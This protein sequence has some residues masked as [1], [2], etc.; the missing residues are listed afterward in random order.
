M[1]T[2]VRLNQYER[3]IVDSLIQSFG[4]TA[5]AARKL[6]V[7]YVEVIRKLGGYDTCY[8]HAERLVQA[9]TI[10][11]KPEDWLKRIHQIA[12]EAAQ[13]KGILHLEARLHANIR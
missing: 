1:K 6:V 13:D 12:K 11:L 7:D 9:K 4:Y 8:D 5:Q 3:G 10:E 2:Q